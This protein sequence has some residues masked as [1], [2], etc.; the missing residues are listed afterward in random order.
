M[1]HSPRRLVD[2]AS[3]RAFG[4]HQHDIWLQPFTALT[5]Y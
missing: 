5:G 2:S 1:A 3:S 4:F